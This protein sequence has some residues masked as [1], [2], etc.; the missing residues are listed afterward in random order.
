MVNTMTKNTSTAEK[1]IRLPAYSSKD[2]RKSTKVGSLNVD[3][4][5]EMIA[6]CASDLSKVIAEKTWGIGFSDIQNVFNRVNLEANLKAAAEFVARVR[7]LA[8]RGLD[9]D[10]EFYVGDLMKAY[11][12][13]LKGKPASLDGYIEDVEDTL[14]GVNQS[15]YNVLLNTL[16]PRG[17]SMDKLRTTMGKK[18]AAGK[19]LQALTEA[20]RN[21]VGPY[22]TE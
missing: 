16:L 2:T 20:V 8:T 3:A 18:G 10:L 14:K 11:Y 5:S 15:L 9:I 21:E 12:R 13:S 7:D 19:L 17:H 1:Q 6:D 4:A 22:F